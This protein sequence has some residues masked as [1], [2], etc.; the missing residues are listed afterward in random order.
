MNLRL[1]MGSSVLFGVRELLH[2][3]IGFVEG[4]EVALIAG[5]NMAYGHPPERLVGCRFGLVAP[6][7][8]H[9]E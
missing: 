9:Y 6:E 8:A 5:L 7:Y 1:L 3:R 4:A 2:E